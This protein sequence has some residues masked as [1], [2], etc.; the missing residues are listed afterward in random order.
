[1]FRTLPNLTR[2]SKRALFNLDSILGNSRTYCDDRKPVKTLELQNRLE[3][4]PVPDL[5]ETLARFLKTAQP[6]LYEA[7]FAGSLS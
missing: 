1:M 3:K 2:L 7:E 6:H 4:L 5:K